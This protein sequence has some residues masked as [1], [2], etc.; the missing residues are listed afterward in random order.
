MN[1]TRLSR[2]INHFKILNQQIRFFARDPFPNKLTHYLRRAELIDSIRL[3][4]RSNSSNSLPTL[5]NTRLL[6]PFVVT[7]ALRSAPN[8]D[9]AL[10]LVESLKIIP[11]FSHNQSTLYALATILAKSGRKSELRSLIDQIISGTYYNIRISFMNLMQWYAAAGDIEA[12]VDTW[13]KYRG[14]VKRGCTE[15]YN[16]VMSSYAQMG[17]NL[18]AVDV[19]YKMIDEGAIPNSRTYTVMIEHLINS[20]KLNSAIEIFSLL[21]LMRI[22]RT[23]KQYSVLVEGFVGAKRFD[24]VKTLLNEMRI[25]GK[26]P[27]HTMRLALQHM[28]EA[29]FVHET[30]DFLREMFPDERIKNI[31]S[32]TDSSD[33]DDNKDV[34]HG[35]VHTDTDEIKLKPWLDPKALAN[36]LSQWSPEVVSILEDTNFV[37]TTR[38]VCKVLRNFSLAETAWNFFC[39]VAYQPG[40]THDVYTVQRMMTLLA[41]YGKVELV[42]KLISKIRSE[43]MKLPLSTIRLIIDFYGISKNAD[44]ALKV[45]RDD[46]TLCGSISKFNLMLLYSSLLRTLTKCNRNLDS[47]D[48]LEEMILLGICPDIQT[49]C[50]LI[51]HF[52]LHGDIKTVQKLFIMV[53]QSDVEPDTYMFKV[54][55]QAYC[56][57]E[58]AALAW[59]VFED[60]KNSNLMPDA[61]TK[62]LL[63][64]SLWK[65]GKR[66]EAA[67]VEESCEEK[68]EVL[69]LV[70]RGHLWTVSSADLTRVYN[71]Y[72]NSFMSTS[73]G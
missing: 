62:N 55:I 53:R 56:K 25:D 70:L 19:F 17:R 63:V 6:D 50:G 23:L 28:Q 32:Y 68:N 59:R 37:W 10:F 67:I 71:I 64:K 14:S 5:L 3:C 16:I 22:K 65:E 24:E 15:S 18:E 12:V 45:F 35:D 46:R 58:R 49:F 47:I 60:M 42:D 26:F 57:C 11:H 9:S 4:L 52:A 73:A 48:A 34:N 31:G 13:D 27:G 8:A 72:S 36:A 30:E 38:L 51:Y 66:K 21:P 39:W 54:L 29:G 20:G 43:G 41:R 44:A 69:P 61:A 40:F 1:F 33:E 2:A 7:H